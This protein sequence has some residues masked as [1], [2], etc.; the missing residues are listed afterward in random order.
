MRWFRADSPRDL[1]RIFLGTV[2]AILALGAV[3][4]IILYI[5]AKLG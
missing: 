1:L 4:A 2:A 3:L 5:V